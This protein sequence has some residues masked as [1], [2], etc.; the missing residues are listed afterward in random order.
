MAEEVLSV[1]SNLLKDMIVV[2]HWSLLYRMNRPGPVHSDVSGYNLNYWVTPDRYNR[3]QRGGGI[4]LYDVKFIENAPYS[5]SPTE[6]L[7]RNTKGAAAHIPYRFN[8]A[9]LFDA[10][11]LHC[12]DALAFDTSTPK[13]YRINVTIAY[14]LEV[15]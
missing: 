6:F 10:T 3:D 2:D 11:T 1:C 15:G 13:G 5:N 8:R 4:V 12:T 7:S 14:D 9:V